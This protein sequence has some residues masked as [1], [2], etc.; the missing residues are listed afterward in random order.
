MPQ[1]LG[2][3][4]ESFP[5]AAGGKCKLLDNF[6][7][8]LPRCNVSIGCFGS[9]GRNP[10]LFAKGVYPYGTRLEKNGQNDAAIE[11]KQY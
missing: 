1:K 6:K 4:R 8:K 2:V 11:Q 3:Q 5:L 9:R 10:A 7:S